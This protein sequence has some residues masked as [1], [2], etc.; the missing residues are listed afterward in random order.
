MVAMVDVAELI[1]RRRRQIM[2]HSVLYYRLNAAYLDD[3]TF[4]RWAQ[5]LAHLQSS[6]PEVSERVT[7]MVDAFRNFTGETGYHL[8]LHDM[9]TL[10]V[11]QQLGRQYDTIP[12][13]QAT[14]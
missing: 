3:A 10:R 13:P 2:V 12:P 1:H 9:A 11:A 5:E 8:P 7:Y 6:H 4:D 14:R